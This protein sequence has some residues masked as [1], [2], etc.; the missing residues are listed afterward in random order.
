MYLLCTRVK[1]NA[2]LCGELKNKYFDMA[3]KNIQTRADGTYYFPENGRG[4]NPKIGAKVLADGR[5]SIFLHYD[6]G[7]MG[8]KRVQKREYLKLY[9]YPLQG[10]Q[11]ARRAITAD[12][13]HTRE[14]ALAIKEKKTSEFRDTQ[15][16]PTARKCTNFLEYM[17]DYLAVYRKADVRVIASAIRKFKA[18]LACEDNREYNKFVVKLP[19]SQLSV[20]MCEDFADYLKHTCKG[21][22]A[23]SAF[24]RFKKILI[25]AVKE[26][27]LP[28]NPA[29]GVTCKHDEDAIAKEI[30]SPEEMQ[31]LADTHYPNQNEEVR[32]AFLFSLMTGLRFCDIKKLVYTD[33]DFSNFMLKV[34]QSKTGNF[35]NIPLNDTALQLC[36]T[37][38]AEE[39]IFKL[40]SH[41]ACLKGLLSW[42]KA[43]GI[44]KRVT[45]HSS[46]HSFAT[47]ILLSGVDINTT[48]NLLGH[49]DLRMTQRYLR[50]IDERKRKAVEAVTI[51]IK[52]D[53]EQG[54]L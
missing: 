5:H 54:R 19:P 1:N 31:K 39:R 15:G 36:G 26:G 46:R 47:A 3:K 51:N 29:D 11:E 6:Y 33:I 2:Y 50:A 53:D 9:L 52:S 30:L 34:K 13:K 44:A 10:S 49:K 18:F 4:N 14:L 12:N 45:W 25:H 22:G 48:R 21:E 17:E 35:V 42:C 38:D 37:G 23:H 8:D 41:T 20:L 28:K 40:P 7:M 24:K 32:R 27:V 43:A 16:C